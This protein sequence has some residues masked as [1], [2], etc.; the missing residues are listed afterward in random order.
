M[1]TRSPRWRCLWN[2]SLGWTKQST[3]SFFLSLQVFLD[4]AG[5]AFR[6]QPNRCELVRIHGAEWH[7]T[8][9]FD[10]IREVVGLQHGKH[11]WKRWGNAYTVLKDH[12]YSF[13][14][15]RILSK[16]QTSS[17]THGAPPF[18]LKLTL[19]LSAGKQ[20]LKIIGHWQF[21]SLKLRFSIAFRGTSMFEQFEVPR[22]APQV[23]PGFVQAIFRLIAGVPTKYVQ[24]SIPSILAPWVKWFAAWISI[25]V[26]WLCISEDHIR[27]AFVQEFPQWLEAGSESPPFFS[28]GSKSFL[29]KLDANWSSCKKSKHANRFSLWFHIIYYHI[30]ILIFPLI[31]EDD[32][33]Y[34]PSCFMLLFPVFAIDA[35]QK[36]LDD[37]ISAGH[38][39][40]MIRN[41][42]R[43]FCIFTRFFTRHPRKQVW[44]DC[45]LRWVPRR[46]GTG[47]VPWCFA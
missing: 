6:F 33:N 29:R 34:E 37:L 5:F 4:P 27:L 46:M 47:S 44:P 11:A 38:V 2:L 28:H 22:T 9:A 8:G 20:N 30:L 31:Q 19:C 15:R 17:S 10:N 3:S 43:S 25:V 24:E 7:E 36:S 23:A 45:H 35:P 39:P 16:K 12:S 40:E 21:P 14:L 41:W 13:M 26:Y 42:R 1:L 32:K 18:S